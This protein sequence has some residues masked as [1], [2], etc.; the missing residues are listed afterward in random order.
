MR[1]ELMKPI[2]VAILC[3]RPLLCE[4]VSAL[5]RQE[6]QIEIV[7]WMREGVPAEG[8]SMHACDLLIVDCSVTSTGEIPKRLD[9]VKR[10]DPRVKILLLVEERMPDDDLMR[11][12]RLGA[13]GYVKMTAAGSQLVE[14][15]QTVNAGRLWA[16]RRLL[17]RFVAVPFLPSLDPS[18]VA[19]KTKHRLTQREREIVALL[20]HGLPNRALSEQLHICE[21]TVKTHLNKIYKKMNVSNRT[22]LLASILSPS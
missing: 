21:A 5:I 11:F 4:G 3:D 19:S 20:I 13:N 15:I 22:E 18:L 12:I 14:A 10:R 9:A 17:N 2:R 8:L 6:R 16:E 1:K 7:A